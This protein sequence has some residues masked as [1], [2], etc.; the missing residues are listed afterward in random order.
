MP[1]NLIARHPE[2]SRYST[3]N[4]EHRAESLVTKSA[5]W[6]PKFTH[7]YKDHL[8]GA[9]YKLLFKANNKIVSFGVDLEKRY[10]K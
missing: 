5:N 9:T 1:W 10:A 4:P 2:S 6:S 3:Y 7:L 8:Q